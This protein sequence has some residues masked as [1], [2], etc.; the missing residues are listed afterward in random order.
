MRWLFTRASLNETED[1]Q[2]RK[3]ATNRHA[4]GHSMGRARMIVGSWD[5][6]RTTAIAQ[7]SGCHPQ[8]VR[9]RVIRFN[10]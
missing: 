8:A 3:L 1:R 4:P 7:Q 6:R 5:K 2:I 10:A 9:E